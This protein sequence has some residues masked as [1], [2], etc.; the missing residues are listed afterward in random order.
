MGFKT[1]ARQVGTIERK[2]AIQ[3]EIQARMEFQSQATVHLA[4]DVLNA[5]PAFSAIGWWKI[6][7]HFR[8]PT[9][10]L[11][12]T[13][14][15][16]I[17]AYFAVAGVLENDGAVWWFHRRSLYGHWSMTGL[18]FNENHIQGFLTQGHLHW[19]GDGN[20]ILYMFLKEYIICLE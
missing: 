2:A 12:W 7:Q 8:A 9:R 14:S 10:L 18:F 13:A 3:I 11:D 1:L 19:I 5:I 16:L 17:A 6:M 15:H 20:G 4:P